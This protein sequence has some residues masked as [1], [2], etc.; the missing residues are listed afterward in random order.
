MFFQIIRHKIAIRKLQSVNA[1]ISTIL[2]YWIMNTLFWIICSK[3]VFD[4][5]TANDNIKYVYLF[6]VVFTIEITTYL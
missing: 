6:K 4:P 1:C 2:N 3:H 5:K